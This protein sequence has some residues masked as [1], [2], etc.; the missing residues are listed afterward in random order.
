MVRLECP[1]HLGY[2]IL[3]SSP[4]PQVAA[5]RDSVVE[6]FQFAEEHK[7]CYLPY[8]D[9]VLL[10]NTLDIYGLAPAFRTKGDP[11]PAEDSSM[12]PSEWLIVLLL[13][14]TGFSWGTTTPPSCDGCPCAFLLTMLLPCADMVMVF[15]SANADAQQQQQQQQG[16]TADG[17]EPG[18][19]GGQVQQQQVERVTL[20]TFR[21]L[22]D[23]LAAQKAEME[24]LAA[25]RDVSIVRVVAGPFKGAIIPSPTA[26]LEQMHEMLPALAA[27]LFHDFMSTVQNA[28]SRLQVRRAAGR[29]GDCPRDS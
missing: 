15:A 2:A 1:E 6:A 4:S 12:D 21:Q 24:A 10:H 27:D 14:Y 13:G 17:T 3:V 25:H 7:A 20:A 23:M 9:M 22:L 28:L 8:R 29:Q 18:S 11:L 5:V 16:G 19:E 26:C